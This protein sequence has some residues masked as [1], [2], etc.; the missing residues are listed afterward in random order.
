MKTHSHNS[1]NTIMKLF[2]FLSATFCSLMLS[3]QN[4]ISYSPVAIDSMFNKQVTGKIAR[5]ISFVLIDDGKVVFEKGYG[6]SDM[7]KAK[8]VDAQN[9]LFSIASVSKIFATLSIMQLQEKGKCNIT[10]VADKYLGYK[11]KNPFSTSVTLFNL[12]T[13]TAGFEDKFMGGLTPDPHELI[14]LEK[15]FQQAMPAVVMEP[16]TQISYSNHGAALAGLIAEKISGTSFDKYVQQNIFDPLEMQHSSFFQPAPESLQ[17]NMV[18]GEYPQPYF[19]PYPAGG[20]VSTTDDMGKL[21]LSLLNDNKI[22]SAESINQIFSK[23]WSANPGMPGMG[24]GFMQ[25]ILKGQE[26]FFHTGDAGQHSLLFLVPKQKTGFFVVYTNIANGSPREDVANLIMNKFHA[27]PFKLPLPPKNFTNRAAEYEGNYRSN[28]Y[29]RTTFEKLGVIPNQFTVTAKENNTLFIEMLGGGLSATLV[30]I[31]K[32]LFISSDSGWFCFIRNKENKIT[33]IQIAGN[34]SDPSGFEKINWWDNV[35]FHAA[36]F[37]FIGL[38]I[39]IRITWSIIKGIKSL[40]N[41]N[42]K[43]ITVNKYSNRAW[44]T[45]GLKSWLLSILLV[46]SLL[47]IVFIPKPIYQIPILVNMTLILLKVIA[48]WSL[49]LPIAAFISWKFDWWTKGKKIF[50]SF[51]TLAMLSLSWLIFYWNL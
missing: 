4:E 10:D 22:L 7:K 44:F 45:T 1:Y 23:Q 35:K 8:P 16:G 31:R 17:K 29:S 3:A 25:S 36:I 41:R 38:I 32:D 43:Q 39:I 5:G 2:F 26:V 34:L 11:I 21:I 50:F 12:L 37:L 42:K 18:R 49:L 9:T 33:G 6:Y 24:L 40:V 20:C 48:V 15:Y 19:N 51:F 46:T 28:Q 13:H 30:E 47:S 27:A 14:P